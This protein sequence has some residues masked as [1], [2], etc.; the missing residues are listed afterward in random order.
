MALGAHVTTGRH[1][2]QVDEPMAVF[3]IGA[4]VNRPLR[5]R[6][7][8]WVSQSMPRM[9]KRLAEVEELGL[10]HTESF[11]QGRTTL[12]LQYW[13]SVDHLMAFA[14]DRDNPHLADWRRFNQQLRGSGDVGIWHETYVVSP[15][16]WE[17]IYVDMPLFG[18]GAALGS[19]PVTATRDRARQRMAAA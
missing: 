8:W 3:L 11:I 10:L 2:A 5:V 18:M 14:T 9:L 12:S 4:R 6:S 1:T 19:V 15:G 16:N 7:W 17:G 13:R